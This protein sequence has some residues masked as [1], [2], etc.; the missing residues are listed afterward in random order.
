MNSKPPVSRF[1]SLEI[2]IS[3]SGICEVEIRR[4]MEMAKCTAY[5]LSL[6][7]DETC[8]K[9]D[10]LNLLETCTSQKAERG[11]IH[12]TGMSCRRRMFRT[13][14]MTLRT[15]VPTVEEMKF[16]TIDLVGNTKTLALSD[17]LETL[18]IK[19]CKGCSSKKSS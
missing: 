5:E 15:N 16:P 1:V 18:M 17:N 3:S 7:Q 12:V 14:W 19:V 8:S 11:K 10:L 13:P 2:V 4:R 6:S 9:L